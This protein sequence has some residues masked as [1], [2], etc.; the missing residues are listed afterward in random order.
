MS[1]SALIQA[2]LTS[3]LHTLHLPEAVPTS[4]GVRLTPVQGYWVESE[5][6]LGSVGPGFT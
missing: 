3:Q 6:V 4:E 2:H 1:E 5:P